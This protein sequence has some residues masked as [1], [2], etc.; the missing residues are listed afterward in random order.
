MK[1]KWKVACKVVVALC[2]A[3][4]L[5]L[6]GLPG[7]GS[8]H[9]QASKIVSKTT[10]G[11]VTGI[12]YD[13]LTKRVSWNKVP[14][15]LSYSV[16]Y[17][18]S[19][20]GKS[21]F[22]TGS[23]YKEFSLDPDTYTL[24]IYAENKE[25]CYCVA[26]N[27]SSQDCYDYDYDTSIKNEDGT[28]DLYAYLKG[29]EVTATFTVPP[30]A[31][32]TAITQIARI[33]IR[34]KGED[35]V[36][37]QPVSRVSLFS[38]EYLVWEY[39]NNSAF[40]NDEKNDLLRFKRSIGT[41]SASQDLDVSYDSFAPGETVYVRAC[42]YN[43]KYVAASDEAKHSAYTSVVTFLVPAIKVTSIG[44]TATAS[45]ITLVARTN[46]EATGYQFAKKVGSK[47]V[48]LDTQTDKTYVDK[49]LSKNS[50]YEYRVRAYTY[51]K[52]T[53]KTIWSD[54]YLVKATTWGSA[55]DFRAQMAGSSSV[56]LT[57]K[58]VSGAEGYEIYR[59]DTSSSAIVFD[60][61]VW[62][63]SF[64]N[65][66]LLKTIPKQKAKS[67]TDKKLKKNAVYS[68]WIRAYKTIGKRKFYLDD[69]D[70]ISLKTGSIEVISNYV[71]SSGKKIIKWKKMTGI[72]GYYIQQRDPKTQEYH[73]IKTLKASAT[74]YTFDPVAVGNDPIT[75]LIVPFDGKCAYSG[76]GFTQSPFL[77]A[78]KNVKAVRTAD[79]VKVSWSAV[80]G[81]DYYMVYRTKTGKYIHTKE[82]NGYSYQNPEIVYEGAVNTQNCHPELGEESYKSVGSY[83][84]NAIRTTSVEDKALVYREV[85][86]DENG[87]PIKI[88]KTSD[89]KDIYQTQE[90]FYNGI[91]GPEP[92][93]T[94]H[95]YIVAHAMDANG[96]T[97]S[98][99]IK[100]YASKPATITYTN[101]VA[102]KV[103]KI[104]S[105]KSK[106][107]GQATVSFKKVKGVDG[108]AIYRCGKK[109]GTYVLIGCVDKKKV[110]FTDA[111]APAGKTVYY[112]V[113]SYIKGEKQANIYSAKTAAKS[114][115]VK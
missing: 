11:A 87:N 5:T 90:A 47:W 93:T 92:G 34:E 94:Y 23:L 35:H 85:S 107:K 38:G 99:T 65:Y 96:V 43:P 67:Y 115:K 68:Y 88:G 15:A 19:E 29:P 31:S 109:N 56:K 26:T 101:L 45:E 91:E 100:G 112:K 28:Y 14:G 52:Y 79:G 104:T 37:L 9:A 16:T 18:G 6:T 82:P 30:A 58:P 75:Y 114:V 105:V 22:T 108:Y 42:V 36:L 3:A 27:V 8:M 98:D 50:T 62:V 25:E 51:N 102:K 21:G 49:A 76:S 71:T 81:A 12:K 83:S 74:S 113:A 86:E 63:D 69:A 4:A 59:T 57:W 89:G 41:G 77:A 95:Y 54:W 55:L 84:I 10:L 39:S 97:Y 46:R 7:I 32:T 48:T 33:K 80:P 70:S 20:G 111:S 110:S 103:S 72:K 1:D 40:K 13:P 78:P 60:K 53:K 44:A 2:F 106:K 61:G 66:T 17:Q 73:T 24:T 64:E